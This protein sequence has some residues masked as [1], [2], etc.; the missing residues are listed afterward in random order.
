M[1]EPVTAYLVTKGIYDEYR[2]LAAFIEH[3]SAQEF[4]DYYNLTV[5]RYSPD[6]KA[7]VEEIDIY[8]PGWRRPVSTEV[9]DGSV[10]PDSATPSVAYRAVEPK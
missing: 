10:V 3:R 6:D 4:A 9:L 8:D 2:F 1:I 7:Q 5:E